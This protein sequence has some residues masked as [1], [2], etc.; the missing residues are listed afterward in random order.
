M[1]KKFAFAL[2]VTSMLSDAQ[3]ASELTKSTFEEDNHTRGLRLASPSKEIKNNQNTIKIIGENIQRQNKTNSFIPS[4]KETISIK[5]SI[6]HT[7]LNFP[8]SKENKRTLRKQRKAM[9]AEVRSLKK[10]ARKQAIEKKRKARLEARR[11]NKAKRKLLSSK[12]REALKKERHAHKKIAAKIKAKRNHRNRSK[13]SLVSH[14]NLVSA[15]NKFLLTGTSKASLRAQSS[16]VPLEVR[17]TKT[18]VQTITQN[19][20]KPSVQI[21]PLKLK[22]NPIAREIVKKTPLK[23]LPNTKINLRQQ[24]TPAFGRPLSQQAR[25]VRSTTHYKID[26]AV[27]ELL[28]AMSSP[29]KSFMEVKANAESTKGQSST[30]GHIARNIELI[31]AQERE[32]VTLIE[33]QVAMTPKAE[34]IVLGIEAVSS[35]SPQISQQMRNIA[36]EKT[37]DIEQ[38]QI[39]LAA[40][41]TPIL[42]KSSSIQETGIELDDKPVLQ[43][44]ASH[45]VT[46]DAIQ[47]VVE[48]AQQVVGGIQQLHNEVTQRLGVNDEHREDQTVANTTLSQLELNE[49]LPTVSQVS[50][51]DEAQ[52]RNDQPEGE[53]VSARDPHQP[54]AVADLLAVNGEDQQIH[55]DALVEDHEEEQRDEEIAD[56]DADQPNTVAD[57]LAQNGSAQE[58]RI[59]ALGEDHEEEQRDEEIVDRGADLPDPVADLLAVNGGDQEI[60]VEALDEE[61][62]D[63]QHDEEIVDRGADQPNP[64]ADLLAVNGDAQQI[65]V[66]ALADEHR[67]DEPEEEVVDRGADLPDPIPDPLAVNGDGQEIRVDALGEDQHRD[68]EPEEE[69]VD[70]GAD[71]PDPVAD[72]LAVNGGDQEIHVEALDEEHRDDQH[73]EEIVDRGADQPN[74]VADL[75]AVNGDAQQIRV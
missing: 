27:S 74:P 10:K 21:K 42:S 12:K 54:N 25:S 49:E 18:P 14:R 64:V 11:L 48:F 23:S 7:I 46:K 75:L 43:Q 45:P 60:H 47:N 56:R 36:E 57:L 44:I 50:D 17:H 55:A 73:D 66:D 6:Q 58:I 32:P 62:R 4:L 13:K 65:R 71:L 38:P 5:G 29:A 70:R 53:E 20:E 40:V 28:T 26:R 30:L 19:V 39:E 1:I 68:D 8:R 59:D 3:S 33:K 37:M 52:R 69:V 63:D 51:G 61:H 9:L 2:G 31:N 15:L 34:S 24:T 22:P 41:N 72:L 67:D 16:R 35:N